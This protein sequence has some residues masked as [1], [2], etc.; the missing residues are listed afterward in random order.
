MNSYRNVGTRTRVFDNDLR[1]LDVDVDSDDRGILP[2][3]TARVPHVAD[4]HVRLSYNDNELRQLK[5]CR[6]TKKMNA[7]EPRSLVVSSR[8]GVWL[9]A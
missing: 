5:T 2:C 3:A 8:D 9:S 1:R 6:V 7:I 4:G